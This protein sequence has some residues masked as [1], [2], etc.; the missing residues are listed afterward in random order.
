MN[1]AQ[2]AGSHSGAFRMFRAVSVMHGRGAVLS[3]G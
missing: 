1:N 3:A 2:C